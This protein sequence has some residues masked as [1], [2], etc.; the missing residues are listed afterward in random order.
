MAK[1][2]RKDKVGTTAAAAENGQVWKLDKDSEQL[3]SWKAPGMKRELQQRGTATATATATAATDCETI[4][5]P[6]C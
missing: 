1:V 6:S 2:Q 3:A 4:F 5:L